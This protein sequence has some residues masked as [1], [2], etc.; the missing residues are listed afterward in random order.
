MDKKRKAAEPA[1]TTPETV[2]PTTEQAPLERKPAGETHEVTYIGPAD[3][4]LPGAGRLVPGEPVTLSAEQAAGVNP[5][6]F[7]GLPERE[8]PAEEEAGE[9]S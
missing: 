8:E 7:E 9:P 2:Q 5:A 3:M 1:P 6:W 4:A